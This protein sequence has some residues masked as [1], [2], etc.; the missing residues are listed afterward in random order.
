MLQLRRRAHDRPAPPPEILAAASADYAATLPVLDEFVGKIRASWTRETPEIHA[1]AD[2]W[3]TLRTQQAQPATWL[4][5][6][7]AL[8]QLAQTPPRVP[9]TTP[10]DG[11]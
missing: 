11:P 5:A 9:S 1:V 6:A 4:V 8:V 2:A 7:I 10:A 3:L